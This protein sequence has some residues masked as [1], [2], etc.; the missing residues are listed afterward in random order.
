[1][2]NFFCLT[3]LATTILSASVAVAETA[4]NAV[5]PAAPEKELTIAEKI[6]KQEQ[7]ASATTLTPEEINAKLAAPPPGQN[8]P[9]PQVMPERK[10]DWSQHEYLRDAEGN[11]IMGTDAS[12]PINQPGPGIKALANP[13]EKPVSAELN[14][15]SQAVFRSNGSVSVLGPDG[16][17]RLPPDGVLTLKDGTT[18]QVKGGMRTEQ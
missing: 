5:A 11:R 4:T 6:A 15:G 10:T 8:T 18:F 12:K 7:E 17:F 2:R 16:K 1:M 9:V 13:P 3:L 14:D